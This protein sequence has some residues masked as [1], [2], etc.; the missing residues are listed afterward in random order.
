MALK[1]GHC[2]G[3]VEE[4]LYA[5]QEAGTDYTL[6]LEEIALDALRK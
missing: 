6:F 3:E 2:N 5:V 1:N 4:G